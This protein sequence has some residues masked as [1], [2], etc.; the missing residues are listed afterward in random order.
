MEHF[1]HL[2]TP[3]TPENTALL[4][5]VPALAPMYHQVASWFLARRTR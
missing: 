5:L 3:G 2:F 1:F 4:S